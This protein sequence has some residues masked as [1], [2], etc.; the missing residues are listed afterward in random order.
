MPVA[1]EIIP[2]LAEHVRKY[3]PVEV[4]L[5]W[6]RPGGRPVTRRLMFTNTIGAPIWRQRAQR[7]WTAAWRKAGVP[8][9]G[10]MNGMHVLRHTAASMWLSGGLNLAKAAAFLGDTNEVVMKVYT[11]FMP[12][13]DGRARDI[14]TAFF[15]PLEA[16]CAPDV[17]GA[18]TGG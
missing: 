4:T 11:H 14:M 18:R 8:D 6:A 5:P 9:R 2:L 12:E 10:R 17:P 3:P 1:A 16:Q 15:A 13:D 7:L